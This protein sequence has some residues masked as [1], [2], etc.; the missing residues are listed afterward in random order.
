MQLLDLPELQQSI[1]DHEVEKVDSCELPEKMWPLNPPPLP[2]KP[3]TT[4]KPFINPLKF[5]KL[6]L[7]SQPVV[8]TIAEE[9]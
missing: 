3:Q 7:I 6:K 9:D 2:E 5:F 1:Y 8:Q 4:E